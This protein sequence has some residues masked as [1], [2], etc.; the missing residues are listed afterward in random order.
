MQSCKFTCSS[1]ASLADQVD[2]PEADIDVVASLISI[3]NEPHYEA[4]D[5]FL[6]VDEAW[7]IAQISAADPLPDLSDVGTCRPICCDLHLKHHL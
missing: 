3:D 2:E 7:G 1:P 6:I 5:P 4:E